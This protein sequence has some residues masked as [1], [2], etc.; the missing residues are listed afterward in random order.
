MTSLATTT[1][2]LK[3]VEVESTATTISNNNNNRSEG[4]AVRSTEI[5]KRWREI[6]WQD[7]FEGK[8]TSN[9]LFVRSAIIRKDL[10]PKY[11]SMYQLPSIC[12]Q[13]IDEVVAFVTDITAAIVSDNDVQESLNGENNNDI[14]KN[15][16]STKYCGFVLKP[17]DSS[18]AFGVLF[19]DDPVNDNRVLEAIK[20]HGKMILQPYPRPCLYEHKYKFHLRMMMLL[21]GDLDV[22]IHK[23]PRMLIATNAYNAKNWEDEYAHITNRSI[24]MKSND[25]NQSKQN[26]K[27]SQCE[28]STEFQNDIFTQM[29][30]IIKKLF[31]DLGN[32][33]NYVKKSEFLPLRTS[34][35]LYG[36]DFLVS[37]RQTVYLLEINPEPSMDVFNMKEQS[38]MVGP[39]P[40]QRVPSTFIK[41]YSKEMLNALNILRRKR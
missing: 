19:F 24:N 33:D 27:F 11:A 31:K 7:V 14:S 34:Y 20:E 30:D 8:T 36:V 38:Q 1:N 13:S 9:R 22:Y 12:V 39:D 29:K 2:S 23:K 18:N 10:L 16:S 21:V 25:Y 26:I 4:G 15:N 17:T 5:S 28:F 35:E 3:D 37:D 41:V 6:N 32:T 40:F